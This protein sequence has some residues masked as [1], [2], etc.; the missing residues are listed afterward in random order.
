ML[1]VVLFFSYFFFNKDET[2]YQFGGDT[3]E[4]D[5]GLPC[6]FP[7]IYNGLVSDSISSFFINLELHNMT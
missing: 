1:H 7:Y 5:E 6:N 3:P 4:L 2:V